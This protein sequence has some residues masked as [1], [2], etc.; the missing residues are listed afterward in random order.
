LLPYEST[1]IVRTEVNRFHAK[2]VKQAIKQSKL[3]N[4]YQWVTWVTKNSAELDVL[5]NGKVFEMG[6]TGKIKITGKKSYDL[7]ANPMPVTNT[8]PNCKCTIIP[9]IEL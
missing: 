5:L 3:T 6:A 9:Y 1:R 2:G 8:H 7:P 4:K